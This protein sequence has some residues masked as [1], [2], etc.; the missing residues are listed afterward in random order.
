MKDERLTDAEIRKRG[1]DA[2]VERLGLAGAL[3]FTMQT[4][5]GAGD[6]VRD[7]HR[8]LGSMSVD[9]LVRRM[10]ARGRRA[11]TRKQRKG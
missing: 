8:A 9:Q 4:E 2:L 11:T 1:W 3:R 5:A 7:R 6:Y 10:G